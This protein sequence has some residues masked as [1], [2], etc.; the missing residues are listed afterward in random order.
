MSKTGTKYILL[1]LF[2]AVLMASCKKTNSSN[3]N[4]LLYNASWSLPAVSAYWN[5]NSTMTAPLAQG[6]SS[7]TSLAP[8]LQL[9]AGTNLVI[10]KAGNDTLVNKNIY[11]P[12]AGGNSFLFFDTSMGIAPARVLQLTDDLTAP[13]TARIKYRFINFS[14]DTA[15]TADLWLVN[16][17]TDS[18]EIKSNIAFVGSTATAS[19]LPAF[20]VPDF[21]YRGQ[22]YTIKIK[23]T[24]TDIV[25]ASIPNYVFAVQGVY[26]IIFSGLST[27]S[28]N[29]GLKLSV[30]HHVAR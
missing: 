24:G 7:G 15:V 25:L 19:S 21:K 3:A 6:Q 10:L 20:E 29:T 12:A 14:P 2:I 18:L 27:G 30:L 4:V 5:G 8:Y 28:G 26:S 17:S 16:G 1:M 23:K 9:P 22:A 11:T 13:D